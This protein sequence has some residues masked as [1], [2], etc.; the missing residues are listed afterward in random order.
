MTTLTATVDRI[1]ARAATVDWRRVLLVLLMAL[2]FAVG[3]AARLVVVA[4]GWLLAWVWAAVMEGFSAAA[5]RDG[6]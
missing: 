4:V 1:N 2:P 3:F 5:K 6:T